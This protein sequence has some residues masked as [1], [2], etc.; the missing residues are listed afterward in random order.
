[1]ATDKQ[2]E[3][4]A[5]ALREA[6]VC[7]PTMDFPCPF[8]FWGKDESGMIAPVPG[9]PADHETGCMYLAKIALDAAN[10]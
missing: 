10:V 9:Q 5:M 4:A 8:C 2:I 6:R 3:A 7:D 1:M